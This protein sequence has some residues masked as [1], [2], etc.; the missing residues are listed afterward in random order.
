MRSPRANQSRR[1]ALIGLVV[2]GAT[3]AGCGGDGGDDD[4]A[5]TK[6]ASGG[7]IT[8]T[9]EGVDYDVDKI[10]AE[11]GEFEVTYVNDDSQQH[12]FFIADEDGIADAAGGETAMYSWDLTAGT[13]KFFCTIPGHEAQGMKGSIVVE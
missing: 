1:I 5:V 3:F 11:P 8:V 4:E 2:A 13:Y 10:L 7:K 12:N 6:T 9:S